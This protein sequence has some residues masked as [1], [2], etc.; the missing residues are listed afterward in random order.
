MK[1]GEPADHPHV[2]AVIAA[3][4]VEVLG[5][6]H[7]DADHAPVGSRELEAVDELSEHDVRLGGPGCLLKVASP[8]AAGLAALVTSIVRAN[9]RSM[10]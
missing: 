5:R 9:P 7:V 4:D 8:D 2:Q 3:R 10:Q 1:V 6:H